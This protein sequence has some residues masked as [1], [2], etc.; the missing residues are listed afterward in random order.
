MLIGALLQGSWRLNSGVPNLG[1]SC[2]VAR[3]FHWKRDQKGC[4][5]K[6]RALFLGLGLPGGV[7]LNL[8][9]VWAFQARRDSKFQGRNFELGGAKRPEGPNPKTGPEILSCSPFG[10]FTSP[11]PELAPRTYPKLANPWLNR[12][13]AVMSNL[14][15]TILVSN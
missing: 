1:M 15:R 14:A 5:S 7:D 8:F 12:G 3:P 13:Y 11:L 4:N 9:E 6:F 10:P 2:A